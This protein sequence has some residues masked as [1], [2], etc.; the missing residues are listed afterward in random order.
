[1]K[2][3]LAVAMFAALV[4]VSPV[5]AADMPVEPIVEEAQAN[6]YV[7]LHGGWK[8]GRIGTTR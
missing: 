2:K 8:F 4:S 1:M 5:M 3:P 6:W 7:S